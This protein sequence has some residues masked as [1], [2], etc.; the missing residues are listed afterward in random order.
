MMRKVPGYKRE[1]KKNAA[2]ALDG[3]EKAFEK[4]WVS[5]ETLNDGDVVD[6]DNDDFSDEIYDN[7]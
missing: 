2:A 3:L 5:D 7:D 6:I 4:R 1:V